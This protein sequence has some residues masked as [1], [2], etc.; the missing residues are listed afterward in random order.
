MC[1]LC[2]HLPQQMRSPVLTISYYTSAFHINLLF[3]VFEVFALDGMCVPRVLGF[4][5]Y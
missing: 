3:S 1:M 4:L 5:L 2:C